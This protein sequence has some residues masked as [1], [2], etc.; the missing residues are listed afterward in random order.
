MEKHEEK[1][2]SGQ[3]PKIDIIEG[4]NVQIKEIIEKQTKNLSENQQIQNIRSE[5]IAIENKIKEI[6]SKIEINNQINKIEL[7]IHKAIS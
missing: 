1:L 7:N 4:I 2:K 5:I 3:M 6:P